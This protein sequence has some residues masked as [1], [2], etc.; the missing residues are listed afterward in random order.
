MPRYRKWMKAFHFE[1]AARP[2]MQFT[3]VRLHV[4]RQRLELANVEV[5]GAYPL[6]PD[7][8]ARTRVIAPTACRKWGGFM[9]ISTTHTSRGVPVTDVRYRLS[10]GAVERYWNVGANDW[11]VASPNNWNTEQ[12]VAD[13]IATWPTQ[14]LGLVIN[15]STTDPQVTP[16][17]NE[18]RLLYETD[19]VS[20]EDYVVRSFIDELRQRMRPISILE[21]DSVGQAT[22]D[23]NTLQVPYDI[24]D[25]DSVY[26]KTT[27][28][29]RMAP[30]LGWAY[31]VPGKL[32]SLPAQ[33]VGD[34]IEVRFAWRPHV[35]LTQSQDYTEIAKIPAVVVTA[36]EL[37]RRRM[38]RVRPYV[39]NK[40]TGQGFAF[41]EGFQADI[42]LPLQ[43]IASSARELHAMNEEISRFFANV[44]SLHSRGQDEFYPLSSD[45]AYDA[46]GF[47]LSL[48]ETFSARLQARILN[49][50]FYPEDARPITGVSRFAV[51]GGPNI[52]VP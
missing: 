40:G 30:V 25:V 8:C 37:Q 11:V 13:H 27:D 20:L 31:D 28:P 7:L 45:T 42:R 48:K 29:M 33:P 1:E 49:A 24:V 17:V 39:L 5:D 15:L 34:R 2:E 46:S 10:D 47:A 9:A 23:L 6:A 3:G 14:A 19:L 38:I 16:H 4:Q 50:V 51:T 43:L 21:F 52:E 18:V 12:E 44:S 22:I 36:I 41:E 32:L 35:V 26:N